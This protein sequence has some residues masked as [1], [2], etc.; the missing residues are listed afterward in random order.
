MTA[1]V[2]KLDISQ[3][4]E[5]FISLGERMP[6]AIRRGMVRA[7]HR[8]VVILHKSTREAPP[9]NPAGIGSGGAVNYGNY[10]RAWKSEATKDGARV[11]NDMPYAGVI[12]KGRRAGRRAPPARVIQAWAIVFWST[13][14]APRRRI[15]RTS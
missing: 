14:L 7:A 1:Q 13:P 12:E 10:L 9:A 4:A 2:I 11:Y 15:A 3:M 5:S 8:A 6:S